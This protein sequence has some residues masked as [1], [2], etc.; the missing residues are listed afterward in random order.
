MRSSGSLTS[1]PAFA[2]L[3]QLATQNARPFP[4][5]IEARESR[6]RTARSR[7]RRSDQR[8]GAATLAS[9]ALAMPLVA[10]PE[11]ASVLAVA[12][13]AL[14]AGQRWA[15]GLVIVAA[16]VL[17]SALLPF[18][19]TQP[20]SLAAGAAWLS[21]A[22]ALPCLFA[23]RRG[24]AALVLLTGM[25]RTPATCRTI[26]LALLAFAVFTGCTPLL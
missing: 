16:L 2:G 3:P 26:H 9:A 15:I 10:S 7:L 17:L 23:T 22:A 5:R 14:L 8:I 11:A 19:L 20:S 1:I 4:A 12:A 18:A 24:A 6:R 21:V 13:I 25:R